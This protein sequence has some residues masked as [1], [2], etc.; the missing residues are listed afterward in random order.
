MNKYEVLFIIRP[1][2]GDHEVEDAVKKVKEVVIRE[3]GEVVAEDMWGKSKLAYIVKGFREGV[4]AQ[5]N[6]TGDPSL[7]PKLNRHFQISEDVIREL[8]TRDE[9]IP[10]IS[11]ITPKPG[12]AEGAQRPSEGNGKTQAQA[13][14]S[15]PSPEP[16]EDETGAQAPVDGTSS[17]EE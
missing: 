17:T 10:R 12:Q 7:I 2:L 4:Y 11:V 6:F 15:S 14:P 1:D 13:P 3:G 16:Q 8:V 9:G 5:L